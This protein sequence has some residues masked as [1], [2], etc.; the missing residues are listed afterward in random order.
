MRR[1]L[2]TWSQHQTPS[3]PR[4]SERL[5]PSET[6]KAVLA[7]A[8]AVVVLVT[9][10]VVFTHDPG[11]SPS[12]TDGY[13]TAQEPSAGQTL[14]MGTP[15]AQCDLWASRGEVPSG[16]IGSDWIEGCA[17]YLQAHGNFLHIPQQP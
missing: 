5:T 15:T 8:A 1:S 6:R 12:W 9:V 3:T 13:N 16:D 11:N 4:P 10:V 14:L 2:A 17:A 7:I